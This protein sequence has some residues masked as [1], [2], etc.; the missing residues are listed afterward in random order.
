M[1]R[2]TP[3]CDYDKKT[4]DFSLRTPAG[5]LH[6]PASLMGNNGLMIAFICNHCPY[7]VSAIE[8]LVADMKALHEMGVGVGCVMSNDYANYPLDAPDQIT[9]FAQKHGIAAPYLVDEDQTVARAFG[10]VCTPDFFGFDAKGGMQYRGR[11]DNLGMRGDQAG[12]V[13]ELVNAMQLVAQTGKGPAEQS[14][15]M[16]CSI[17]WR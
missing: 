17:K 11:L 4:P 1:L 10:A 14:P 12:R 8:R 2:E 16:G 5:E 15:S 3:A 9:L 6:I 7:V 13:P